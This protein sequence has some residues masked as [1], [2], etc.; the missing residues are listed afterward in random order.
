LRTKETLRKPGVLKSK[1]CRF[2]FLRSFWRRNLGCLPACLCIASRK[3][4]ELRQLLPPQPIPW[5]QQL[6]SSGTTLDCCFGKDQGHPSDPVRSVEAVGAAAPRQGAPWELQG[7]TPSS[8]LF[9]A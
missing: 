7:F 4:V 8:R 1:L 5:E 9:L 3:W 2:F 6:S